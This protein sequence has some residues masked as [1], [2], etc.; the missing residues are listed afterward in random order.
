MSNEPLETTLEAAACVYSK[1]IGHVRQRD[2][3][4][5]R[6]WTPALDMQAD[7]DRPFTFHR[8]LTK[9]MGRVDIVCLKAMKISA[10]ACDM[11]QVDI[12]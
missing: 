2:P 10:A 6:S 7:E 5:I 1:T 12:A 8:S 9:R 4:T 3:Y 11:N